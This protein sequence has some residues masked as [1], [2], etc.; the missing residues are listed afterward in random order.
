VA[1]D[2]DNLAMAAAAIARARPGVTDGGSGTGL[3]RE[4]ERMA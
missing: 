4:K 1:E 3:A 2:L